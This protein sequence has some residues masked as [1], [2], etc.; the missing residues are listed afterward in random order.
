MNR[1]LYEIDLLLCNGTMSTKTR[2]AIRI[3]LNGIPDPD[4]ANMM[5][6]HIAIASPEAAIQR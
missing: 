5:G 1:Y 6:I 2:E 4:L 3:A